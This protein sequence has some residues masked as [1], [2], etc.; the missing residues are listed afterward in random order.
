MTSTHQVCNIAC[1]STESLALT[2]LFQV[3]RSPWMS[4]TARLKVYIR[5]NGFTVFQDR[6]D[7]LIKP[8]RF[9]QF[10]CLSVPMPRTILINW[11]NLQMNDWI[12]L[13]EYSTRIV[14][15]FD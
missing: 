4:G 8:G 9:S 7:M 2:R 15:L 3:D 13:K 12:R 6:L 10:V 1:V 11:L 14:I 5:F